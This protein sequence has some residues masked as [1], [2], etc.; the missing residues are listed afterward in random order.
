MA[1]T[2]SELHKEAQRAGLVPEGTEPDEYTGAQL[3]TLLGGD[4]P[5]SGWVPSH[6]EPQIAPDGHPNLSKEDIDARKANARA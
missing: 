5:A 2:K 4:V 3:E 1:K 6:N